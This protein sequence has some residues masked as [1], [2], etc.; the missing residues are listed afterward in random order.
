M[1][2]FGNLMG[3]L[4]AFLLKRIEPA[5]VWFEK[6]TSLVGWQI[7]GMVGVILAY[8]AFGFKRPYL[9]WFVCL[10]PVGFIELLVIWVWQDY[11]TAF[12]RKLFKKRI[13]TV[14]TL[15]LVPVTWW[16]FGPVAAGLYFI[17]VLSNHFGE[18][19]PKKDK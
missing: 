1:V 16:W 18:K 13:D 15:G 7:I 8:F 10:V 3:W 17:G 12:G 9:G 5:R 4:M 19:Q 2:W 11:I 6:H 14:I